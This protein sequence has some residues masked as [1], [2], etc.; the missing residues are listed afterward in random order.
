MLYSSMLN[1]STIC[2]VIVIFASLWVPNLAIKTDAN[3]LYVGGGGE[4]NYSS[5]QSAINDA[6]PGDI[7]FVFD[8]SS[9][10]YENICINKSIILIGENKETTIING[11][12]ENTITILS[13]SVSIERFTIINDYGHGIVVYS[14]N[15]HIYGNNIVNCDLGL[16]LINSSNNT[17]TQNFISHN[18]VGIYIESSSNNNIFDNI[19][20]SSEEWAG[21]YFLFSDN[22]TFSSNFVFNCRDGIIMSNSSKNLVYKNKIIYN[23][24]CGMDMW[25]GYGNKICCN[26]ISFNGDDAITCYSKQNFISKNS[27]L[28]NEEYGLFIFSENNTISFNVVKNNGKDGIFVSSNNNKIIGNRI[29]SNWGRGIYLH[30][31]K[32]D[33]IGDNV[34]VND[35]LYMRNSVKNKVFNNTV[36][37]KPLVCLEDK[38]NIEVSKVGEVILIGCKNI[39]IENVSISNVDV[40]IQLWCCSNCKILNNDMARSNEGI[41]MSFSCDN[42]ISNNFI[43]NCETG[44][45]LEDADANIIKENVILNNK[46]GV[47]LFSCDAN[48]ISHNNFM[49]NKRHASFIFREID[50]Y[51]FAFNIWIRNYW[52]RPRILPKIILGYYCKIPVINVDCFPLFMPYERCL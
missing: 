12:Y 24:L 36:N 28:F 44:I 42:I 52:D 30:Y 17:I 41:Y 29:N 50:R 18:S 46:L 21:V 2:V 49:K 1:N 11:K 9:P 13:D 25:G 47:K 43:S 7:I 5:I 26:N 3:I 6:L 4:G 33:I 32:N 27:I 48:F 8:E 35:S 19:I 40:A 20:F 16:Y 31:S 23:Q 15:N 22:N 45:Y 38:V 14:S 10:Y 51:P 37:E 39:T 34:F